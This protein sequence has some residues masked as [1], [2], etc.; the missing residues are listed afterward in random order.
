MNQQK[1]KMKW[2]WIAITHPHIGHLIHRD[3]TLKC[4][5]FYCTHKNFEDTIMLI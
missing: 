1:Y 5:E 3:V 4:S 2:C